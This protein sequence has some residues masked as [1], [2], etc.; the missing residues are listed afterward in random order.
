MVK[1]NVTGKGGD[2]E[3]VKEIWGETDD[4]AVVRDCKFVGDTDQSS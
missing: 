4:P 1:L 3:Y 2:L